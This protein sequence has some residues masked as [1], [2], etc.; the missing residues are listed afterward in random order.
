MFT[1]IAGR[2]DAIVPKNTRMSIE[3]HCFCLAIGKL[4]M[5]QKIIERK[6]MMIWF[7]FICWIS[8]HNIASILLSIKDLLEFLTAYFVLL[9]Y[10]YYRKY[11]NF[12]VK[13]DSLRQFHQNKNVSFYGLWRNWTS[14][15]RSPRF[16]RSQNSKQK[17]NIRIRVLMER[18]KSATDCV[19]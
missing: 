4:K 19:Y 8:W 6:F 13:F 3:F 7:N 17:R 12:F 2:Y 15:M 10:T 9:L 1:L 18:E 5:I 16:S 11:T 14:D